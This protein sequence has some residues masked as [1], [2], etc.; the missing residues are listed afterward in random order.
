MDMR[1]LTVMV[2]RDPVQNL[3]HQYQSDGLAGK[4]YEPAGSERL[5]THYQPLSLTL[6][7]YRI[8]LAHSESSA[9]PV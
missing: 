3:L 5:N 7:I 2:R 8:R 1:L 4:P 9:H 6:F